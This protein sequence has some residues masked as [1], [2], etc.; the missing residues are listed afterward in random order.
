MS[1][2]WFTDPRGNYASNVIYFRFRP[3]GPFIIKSHLKSKHWNN[4]LFVKFLCRFDGPA[5][6]DN[7]TR[8][9]F[10]GYGIPSGNFLEWCEENG[11]DPEDPTDEEISLIMMTWGKW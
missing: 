1:E 5:V 11:V 9:F 6:I 7:E 2:I 4:P 8:H 10:F 3:D